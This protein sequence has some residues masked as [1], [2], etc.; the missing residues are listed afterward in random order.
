MFRASKHR[1]SG[2]TRD[3]RGL[4]TGMLTGTG[5]WGSERVIKWGRKFGSVGVMLKIGQNI[6]F[7]HK[8]SGSMGVV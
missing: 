6:E 2:L 1:K 3:R 5:Y 7:I 4:R 8:I